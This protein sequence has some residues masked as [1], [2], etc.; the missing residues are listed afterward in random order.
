MVSDAETDSIINVKKDLM[1][2]TLRIWSSMYGAEL[3]VEDGRA[4]IENIMGFFD[5]LA[6]W[7]QKID[8]VKKED[9]D[10]GS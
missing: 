2:K 9:T 5:T 1:E 4:I 8:D 3:T 7:Q 6:D 10:D